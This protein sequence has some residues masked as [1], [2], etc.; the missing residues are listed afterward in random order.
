MLKGEFSQQSF[1]TFIY[2]SLILH[3]GQIAETVKVLSQLVN[4]LKQK[5]TEMPF[6]FILSQMLGLS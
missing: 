5:Q 4:G 6:S 2:D 1:P 3:H